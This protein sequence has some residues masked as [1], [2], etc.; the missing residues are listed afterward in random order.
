[1]VSSLPSDLTA[2]NASS[3]KRERRGGEN[4]S[5]RHGFVREGEEDGRG[6]RQSKGHT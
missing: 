6:T 2:D 3:R 5:M 4:G 1:M